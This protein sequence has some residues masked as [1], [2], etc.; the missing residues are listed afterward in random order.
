M[1]TKLIS[2]PKKKKF[3]TTPKVK[4]MKMINTYC[5]EVKKIVVIL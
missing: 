3:K 4:F 2:I 5:I 1:F